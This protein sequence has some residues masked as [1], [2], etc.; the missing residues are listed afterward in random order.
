MASKSAEEQK[1]QAAGLTLFLRRIIVP[2]NG[3]GKDGR[4][5]CLCQDWTWNSACLDRPSPCSAVHR[6][7]R[8]RRV[9]ETELQGH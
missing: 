1:S 8:W 7:S 6:M 4:L 2:H 9:T 3:P 5:E